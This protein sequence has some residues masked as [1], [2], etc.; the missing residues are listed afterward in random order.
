MTSG[1]ELAEACVKTCAERAWRL[2]CAL[3]WNTEDANDAVQQACLVAA[4]KAGRIPAD[5]PWPWFARVVML[6]CL[7]VREARAKAARFAAS[8]QNGVAMDQPDH[9]LE[10]REMQERLR[11]A[12]K[13]LPTEQ[14]D[15]LTLTH[16]GGLSVREAAA[17]LGVS[18]S[19]VDRR[20]KQGLESL[21]SRLGAEK[22]AL[23]AAIFALPFD[24][25]GQGMQQALDGW[26][27]MVHSQVAAGA[28]VGGMSMKYVALT[29][30]VLLLFGAGG[31]LVYWHVSGQDGSDIHEF[32]RQLH[33]SNHQPPQ[34]A[35]HS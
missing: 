22:S 1:T 32:M 3:L 17:T 28:S 31:F 30:L 11:E 18:S 33:G 4:T 29:C 23:S 10:S 26:L 7:K 24:E 8:L 14:R 27:G 2:A 35:Q 21:R 20:A 9:T 12:L 34:G 25:P 15:A 16:I 13:Q 19:T 6:E 5:D